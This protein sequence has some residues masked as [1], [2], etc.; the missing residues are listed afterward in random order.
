MPGRPG[1]R[2][3][4]NAHRGGPA[5]LF[6][7]AAGSDLLSGPQQSTHFFPVDP[8]EHGQ[9]GAPTSTSTVETPAFPRDQLGNSFHQGRPNVQPDGNGADEEGAWV[10]ELPSLA[11]MGTARLPENASWSRSRAE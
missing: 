2:D 6:G 11:P 9:Y 7:T 5:P 4:N 3:G 10:D 8:M 1:G